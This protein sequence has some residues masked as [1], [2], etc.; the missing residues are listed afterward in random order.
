MKYELITRHSSSLMNEQTCKYCIQNW[1]L[2]NTENTIRAQRKIK[3]QVGTSI[4]Q[5]LS[6][7]LALIVNWPK[8]ELLVRSLGEGLTTF[9]WPVA[10]LWGT[11]LSAF[12]D[13][14]GILKVEVPPGSSSAKMTEMKE[15]ILFPFSSIFHTGNISYPMHAFTDSIT[16]F[17]LFLSWPEDLS[18]NQGFNTRLALLKHSN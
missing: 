9:T 8:L 13:V 17:I 16:S 5:Y 6:F 3:I 7:N 10:C 4:I 11:V 15:S 1:N 18:R 14:D 2:D 12:N